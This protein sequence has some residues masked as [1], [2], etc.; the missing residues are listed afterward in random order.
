[1]ADITIRQFRPEDYEQAMAVWHQ[2]GLS[3]R[4]GDDRAAI[5]RTLERNPGLSHVAC[6]DGKI[7]ATVLGTYDGRR[8]YIYHLGVLPAYRRQGIAR[9]LI[10]EVMTR[11]AALGCPKLNLSVAEDNAAAISFYESLGLSGNHRLM[12]TD[13]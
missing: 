10:S 5:A 12:G 4:P 9:R 2:A 6:G 13:L 3:V 11:L 1:M 7:V 8:G